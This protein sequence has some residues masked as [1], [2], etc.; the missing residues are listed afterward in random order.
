MGKKSVKGVSQYKTEGRRE[1]NKAEKR[2]RHL[3]AHPT[4]VANNT[5]VNY[6]RKIIVK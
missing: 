3:K 2:A 5:K 6:A 1:T 4:D